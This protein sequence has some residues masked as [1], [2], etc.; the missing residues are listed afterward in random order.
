MSRKPGFTTSILHSDREA[1]IEF[2]TVFNDA[3]WYK[4][5][6]TRGCAYRTDARTV[7]SLTCFSSDGGVHELSFD[8]P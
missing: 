8:C 7:A 5:N 3:R 6:A 1:P 4:A 2:D